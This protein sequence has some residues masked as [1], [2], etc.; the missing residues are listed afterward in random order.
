M[1]P[2][3]SRFFRIPTVFVFLTNEWVSDVVDSAPAK[4]AAALNDV[5]TYLNVIPTQVT[6]MTNQYQTVDANVRPLVSGEL[7]KLVPLK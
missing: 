6:Y 3:S 4:T 1:A 7:L 5:S 2:C